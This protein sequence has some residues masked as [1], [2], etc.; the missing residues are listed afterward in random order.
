MLGEVLFLQRILARGFA[1]QIDSNATAASRTDTAI[2][3]A[4]ELE[5]LLATLKLQVGQTTEAKVA[6][7]VLL[8]D[9]EKLQLIAARETDKPS[10]GQ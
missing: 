2:K 6:Q 1:M 8:S 10:A 5:Q 7:I 4:P 9:A 3:L